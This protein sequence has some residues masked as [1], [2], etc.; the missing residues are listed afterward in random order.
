MEAQ[1]VLDTSV[2]IERESGFDILIASVCLNRELPVVS[3][4]KHFL[5]IKKVANE[6]QVEFLV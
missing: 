6:L 4:D 3:K 5:T 2:A 1:K